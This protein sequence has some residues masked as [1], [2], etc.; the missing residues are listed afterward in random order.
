MYNYSG[1]TYKFLPPPDSTIYEN[2]IKKREELI[3]GLPF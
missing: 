3:E 1:N 2:P